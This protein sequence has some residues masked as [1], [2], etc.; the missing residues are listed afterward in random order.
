MET[1]KILKITCTSSVQFFFQT[2]SKVVYHYINRRVAKHT[3]P[4]DIAIT[5]VC[6]VRRKRT[7]QT[8]KSNTQGRRDQENECY[9]PGKLDRVEAL[10]QYCA[11]WSIGANPSVELVLRQILEQVMSGKLE[12]GFE[13]CGHSDPG[14]LEAGFEV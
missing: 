13:I 1:I 10:Q 12:A 2:H 11:Q 14:K 5:Y 9:D 8:R 4:T 6:I 7:I 3:D